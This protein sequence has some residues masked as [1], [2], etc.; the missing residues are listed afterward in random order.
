MAGQSTSGS[1]YVC[2]NELLGHTPCPQLMSLPLAMDA[3][4]SGLIYLV[5][6]CVVPTNLY[7]LSRTSTWWPRAFYGRNHRSIVWGGG[8]GIFSRSLHRM[9][10]P[11][12]RKDIQRSLPRKWHVCMRM[13]RVGNFHKSKCSILIISP[14]SWVIK[15]SFRLLLQKDVFWSTLNVIYVDQFAANYDIKLSRINPIPWCATW[16]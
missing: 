13:V 15:F 14:L 5:H 1:H 9:V 4:S 8:G 11:A 12:R 6:G 2:L 16:I 10:F 7:D 3:R